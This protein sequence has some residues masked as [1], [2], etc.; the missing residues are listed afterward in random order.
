[1]KLRWI[2]SGLLIGLATSAMPVL[3]G[4]I[5][6]DAEMVLSLSKP[7]DVVSVLVYLNQQVDLKSLDEALSAARAPAELR[8]ELVIRALQTTADTAQF[9]LYQHLQ[10]LTDAN[11]VQSFQPFW[12]V[13]AFRV[14]A[15]PDVIRELANH[16]DVATIYYNYPIEGIQPVETK[17]ASGGQDTPEIGLQVIHVPEVWALGY[18]GEGQLV[19]TLDTGVDGTHPALHDRWRGLDPNYAGHPGWAFFD[20]VTHWQTP[21]DSG[22]HGTHTMGTI[23]GGAPGDQVGVAPGAQFIQAAVIDRVSLLQ[24]CTD[25]VLAFQWIADPDGN[26]NTNFDVPQTNSNSWGIAT[27]HNI[28][29]WSNPCDTSFWQ[30][31]DAAETA[32]VVVLF[33]AG[34]EGPSPN[35]HRRPADRATDDYLNVS[36]GAVDPHNPVLPI[37]DFSSRGPTTCTPNGQSFVKPNIAAP[38]V[39]IRSSVPGNSYAEYSGTSMASPHINGVCALIRQACPDLTVTEVKQILYSTAVDK[40]PPGKDNDYGWGV[41]DA[42]ACVNMAISMC[43]SEEGKISLDHAQYNCNS[44]ANITVRDLGLNLDPNAIDT[45]TVTVSSNTQPAGIV[46][47]CYETDPNSSH[48]VGTVQLSPTGG[49]GVLQVSNGDTV[50][51]TYIDADNG[52]GGHNVPVVT[53]ATVDCAAPTIANV[54]ATNLQAHSAT[55]AMNTNELARATVHYG[56]NC[57]NLNQSATGQSFSITPSVDLTGLMDNTTYF[58][59]VSVVDQA[60]NTATDPNCYTFATPEVP[61][62]FT[63]LFASGWDLQ[64]LTLHFVPNGSVDY[65]RGCDETPITSL[66]TDPN[67][68]TTLSLSDDSYVQV[69]LTGGAQV[70]LYGI[71][72]TRFFVGSNGYITFNTGDTNLTPSLAAHFNQPR[73]TA[74]MRDLNPG[75]GGT[76]SWKQLA[77]RV[78]LTFWNVPCYSGCG[79][80]TFQIEMFFDGS[81][82]ISYLTVAAS[83]GL[84]GLS[85]RTSVPPDFFMSDLTAE[86]PCGPQPPR[87][88][89]ANVMVPV[90]TPTT[91]TLTA[92]DDGLPDPP[93]ALTYRIMSLP[94][95]GILSDPGAGPITQAPYDLVGYGNHVVYTPAA[96]YYGNDVFQFVADDSGTP[97]EG[98]PSDPAMISILVLYGPPTITTSVLP[99][100]CLNHPYNVQF[101]AAQGQPPLS[102]NLIVIPSYGEDDLGVGQFQLMGIARGWH[103]DNGSWNYLLPFTFP[104]FGTNYNSV[105][106]CSNGFLDFTS[107]AAPS[108]NSDSAL[109]AAVRIAPLWDDLQTNYNGGDDVYIS[110][111]TPQQVTIRWKATT[112]SG[113]HPVNFSVTLYASGEIRFHYGSGNTGLTPT[114]G[115]SKGDGVDYTLSTYNNAPTLTGAN[116]HKFTRLTTLPLG[117]T[118]NAFGV[119]SGT[120]L[121]AGTF[122]PRFRVTDSLNRSAEETFPLVIDA[123]CALLGDLN[124][125]GVVN[126]D[127]IDPFVLALS[128]PAGYH[129][130]YPNCDIMNADCNADGVVNFDDIDPFVAILSGG[131]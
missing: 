122:S 51:A 35:T 70:L 39:N 11:A 67:G 23:C 106:V 49:A 103:A 73:I 94:S 37:A 58:F 44:V 63:E 59:S 89:S 83:D 17:P 36:V 120:P 62:Y 9:R 56:L 41:V 53:T 57:N 13:N 65:Y 60:G 21:Q 47:T 116:S 20:P 1:M 98:G 48:F 97:P 52:S 19:S 74:L 114:V 95:H 88:S 121:A 85:G 96:G 55:I 4:T 127:D 69:N 42:L 118:F 66:P 24:T 125:D 29:P 131:G 129:T 38:G 90:N 22:S 105:W 77:D 115:I 80:N 78:A 101:E 26:P 92:L 71:S 104:Y 28:P 81:L 3:A 82:A 45:T 87:A 108:D 33:S 117:L 18:H 31:I 112:V 102:W 27:S 75:V 93:A 86:G 68:G 61:D 10:Q 110:T 12:I 5:D 76:V 126:F 14:N 2:I 107:S 119:L 8:H 7:D 113:H 91:V 64:N 128:N 32:G 6:R 54:H 123:T 84:A 124:C 99:N 130:A 109:A 46:I 72:Y 25:A 111:S 100:G 40:G 16:A 50:T 34:N 79:P 15:T 30:W 43:V